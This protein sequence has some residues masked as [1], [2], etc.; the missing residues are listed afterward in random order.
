MKRSGPLRRRSPM[1][2]ATELTRTAI[3]QRV[4]RKSPEELLARQIVPI[5]SGGWC[6]TDGVSPASDLHLRQ[7]RSQ[8]G[9][10]SPSNILHICRH[11]H[12]IITRTI[13]PKSR[14]GWVVSGYEDPAD[15]PVLLYRHG[16]VL[17]RADGSITPAQERKA[18]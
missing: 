9:D 15:V 10:W 5:R 11:C 7:R 12:D 6:E 18:A 1:R 3:K 2:R 13:T 16:W 4:K 17:L 8:G 14:G